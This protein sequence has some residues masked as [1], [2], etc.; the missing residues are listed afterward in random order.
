[1]IIIEVVVAGDFAYDRGWH[2]MFLTNRATG[3]ATKTKYRYFE[4]WRKE[5]GVWKIDYIITNRELA[6]RML[7]EEEDAP[8]HSV[9][10]EEKP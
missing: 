6:P 10:V 8:A 2:T 9:C 4:T 3:E 1:M 7:P 5:N